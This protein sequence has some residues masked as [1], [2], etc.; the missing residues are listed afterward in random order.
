M[1]DVWTGGRA[2]AP[3]AFSPLATATVAPMTTA[4]LGSTT[5]T[6][7]VPTPA[8]CATALA[9][10]GPGD[11]TDARRRNTH[12]TAT[13]VDRIIRRP[14]TR[15]LFQLGRKTRVKGLP[16]ARRDCALNRE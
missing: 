1:S 16:A 10:Q 7:S 9:A 3:A 2:A 8:V 5:V 6:R 15:R 13:Q 4:P 12:S 14:Q 11:S